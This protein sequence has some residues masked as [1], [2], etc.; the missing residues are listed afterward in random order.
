[1]PCV[2]KINSG[3]GGTEAQD[4]AS[5]LM[6]MYLRYAES[7][8]YKTTICNLQDGDEAGI[9]TVTMEIEGEMAYGFLKAKT[10]CIVSCASAPTMPRVSA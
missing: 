4:W 2:L 1:M 9:K 10:A 8:G 6:R 5:M 7:N 3:A